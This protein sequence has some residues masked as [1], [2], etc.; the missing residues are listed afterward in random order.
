[1]KSSQ[2]DSHGILRSH[3][4]IM[5]RKLRFQICFILLACFCLLVL[6]RHEKHLLVSCVCHWNLFH[7]SSLCSTLKINEQRTRDSVF[8]IHAQGN[9]EK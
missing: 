6:L 1:M 8:G 5:I 2:S 4:F 3:I 7:L 9:Q